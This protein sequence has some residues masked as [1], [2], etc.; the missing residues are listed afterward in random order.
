MHDGQVSGIAYF[1]ADY[2]RVLI[3]AEVFVEEN[4]ISR[5]D[6]CSTDISSCRLY[7][8]S[9]CDSLVYKLNTEVHFG[10]R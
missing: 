2:L 10:K 5:A 7:S 8:D 6:V 3:S 9:H 4:G 1:S